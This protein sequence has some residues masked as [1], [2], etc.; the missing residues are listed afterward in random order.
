LSARP[1]SHGSTDAGPAEAGDRS[2][3][4]DDEASLVLGLRRGDVGALARAFDRWHHRVRV[5][6]RRLLSDAAA[7]E[8]LVQDV[9]EALPPAARRYRGDVDLQTFLYG[10][11]VNRARRHHRAA[12][13]RRRALVR[14]A[15][16]RPGDSGDPE[17]DAYSRELGLRLGA[18][19]DRLPL[20]QRVAFVLCE[21]EELTSLEAA[22]IAAVPEATM[23]TRLFHARR[24]LREWLTDEQ[25]AP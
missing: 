22:A 19:L 16:E 12:A 14:L 25:H 17:H 24:R 10:I 6:A 8:D 13:R 7:A 18:A 21:V 9:F 1:A 4:G 3:P 23:R 5:L 2:A 20:A 11:T 15:A